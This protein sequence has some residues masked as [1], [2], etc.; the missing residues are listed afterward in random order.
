MKKKIPV[1]RLIVVAI[2][3]LALFLLGATSGLI[4][5]ICFAYIGTFLPLVMSFVYLYTSSKIQTFGAP[6]L[7]NGF[8]LVLGLLAGEGNVPLIVGLIGLA[9]IAEIVRKI[10]GYKTLKG[11]RLSFIPFAFSF[12]SYTFHWWTDKSGTL[13]AAVE[14]MSAD[15]ATK[16]ESV[17]DNIP[18]LI[19]MLVLT[20]PVA[21]LGF[22]LAEKAMKKQVLVLK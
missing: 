22:K 14:E 13:A 11:V 12:Y 17:I 10:C 3:Y 20:I 21:L 7:L 18:L 16:V 15:Y 6:T 8:V 9:V 1:L 19:I 4:H 2:I 5:P